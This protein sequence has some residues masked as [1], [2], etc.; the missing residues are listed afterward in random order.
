MVT[1]G[2]AQ[3]IGR[4]TGQGQRGPWYQ[5]S[6]VTDGEPVTLRCSPHVYDQCGSCDFGE[7]IDFLLESRLFDRQW[8]LSISSLGE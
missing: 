2:T 6:L 4:K 3:F 5:I 7:E 1:K 8:V